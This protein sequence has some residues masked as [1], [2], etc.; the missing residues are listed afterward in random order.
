MR[1]LK[2]SRSKLSKAEILKQDDKSPLEIYQQPLQR[3]KPL[4][5]ASMADATKE[6]IKRFYWSGQA[7]MI[8]TPG[9]K[10]KCSKAIKKRRTR[11][12]L[13]FLKTDSDQSNC[14]NLI[15]QDMPGPSK[16]KSKTDFFSQMFDVRNHSKGGRRLISSAT[17]QEQKK[18]GN[19]GIGHVHA[20]HLMDNSRSSEVRRTELSQALT[21]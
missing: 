6:Q 15:K 9:Y 11:A 3:T 18:A 1:L 20:G 19:A 5:V 4:L 14:L 13:D 10:D 21:P 16:N 7:I 12:D 2:A 8:R 17:S